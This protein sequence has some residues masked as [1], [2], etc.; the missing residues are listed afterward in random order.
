[1]SATAHRAF[2]GDGE[3]R[4]QLTPSLIGELEVKTG[5]G[6]GA[7]CTR[8]FSGTWRF[9]D[10]GEIIRLGLIG[11]GTAPQDAARLVST[12]IAAPGVPVAASAA[13]AI[14]ILDALVSGA[15]KEGKSDEP[16]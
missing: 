8:L 11:G 15:P 12:Y 5:V 16:A 2:L 3:H 13:L 6:L 14:D 4:F 1:M 7:L 10:L 9:D